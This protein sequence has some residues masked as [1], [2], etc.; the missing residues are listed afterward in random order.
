MKITVK[1]S[2]T[3]INKTGAWRTNRPKFMHDKCTA[4]AIC[5]RLC[6]EGIIYQTDQTNA[7]GKKYFECDLTYCKGCGLC[8][9][10]CPFKAIEMELDEK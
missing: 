10:E 9:T 4:C 6:P 8:A 7:I 5:S 1:P 2:T 3:T